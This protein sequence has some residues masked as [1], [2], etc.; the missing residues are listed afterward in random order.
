MPCPPQCGFSSAFLVLL[1]SFV[2]AL[3]AACLIPS[4]RVPSPGVSPWPADAPQHYR[5]RVPNCANEGERMLMRGRGYSP[6][7]RSSAAVFCDGMD[8]Q[9]WLAPTGASRQPC[10]RVLIWFT[11]TP[12]ARE[13]V[14]SWR[15]ATVSHMSPVLS[16]PPL[17]SCSEIWYKE[18]R[19]LTFLD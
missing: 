8:V 17:S 18:S 4:S 12:L 13:S 1:V 7:E 3:A 6:P 15:K 5:A 2:F 19:G 11:S 10:P 14:R 16:L 9:P